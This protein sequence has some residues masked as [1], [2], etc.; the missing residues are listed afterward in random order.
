MSAYRNKVGHHISWGFN[1]ITLVGN[2][3]HSPLIKRPG[4]VETRGMVEGKSKRGS[5]IYTFLESPLSLFYLCHKMK[6]FK[7]L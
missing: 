6:T 7:F 4:E 2:A 3:T 1:G 5:C